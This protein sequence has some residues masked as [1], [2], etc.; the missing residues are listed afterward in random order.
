MDNMDRISVALERAR[1]LAAERRKAS[2][3][4]DDAD[5][6]LI[7]VEQ[8]LGEEPLPP[9]P[10]GEFSGPEVS[11]APYE[12]DERLREREK[13]LSP[14][15]LGP[16][17]PAYKMLRTQVLKRMDQ[18]KARTLA[19]IGATEDVGKTLTAIN[20]A[21]AIAAE[22]NRSVLLVDFDLRRPSIQH[23]LGV[24]PEIGVEECLEE[25]R[26]V[27]E[28]MVRID[29][30]DRLTVLLA[31]TMVENSSELLA[32]RNT[33]AIVTQLRDRYPNRILIFDLPPL[34]LADDALAFSPCV[35]AA[36]IVVEERRT[37]REDLVRSLELLREVPVVGTVLN[38]SQ[39]PSLAYY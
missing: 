27:T 37:R 31:R 5:P 11:S 36:L 38:N 12:L 34:L 25:G 17:G 23:R 32:D 15:A 29:G 30:Y 8:A 33:A 9:P 1:R 39:K 2:G 28:A 18:L 35:Q 24:E 4:G 14:D 16:N 21:I 6:E 7:D 19:V 3:A 20:L 13:I 26:P 22:K 10:P